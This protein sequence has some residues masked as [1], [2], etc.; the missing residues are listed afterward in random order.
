MSAEY[1]APE[2][3]AAPAAPA[4]DD[5][6]AAAM[7]EVP[8]PPEAPAKRKS[9]AKTRK[10]VSALGEEELSRLRKL[11]PKTIAKLRNTLVT[12]FK[13]ES[14]DDEVKVLESAG[15]ISIDQNRVTWKL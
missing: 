9:R 13:S 2:E 5:I 8:P 15:V 1:A 12:Q 6:F 14:P 11:A 7:A 3:P 4:A 10:P